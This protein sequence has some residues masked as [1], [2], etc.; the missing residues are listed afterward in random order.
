MATGWIDCINFIADMFTVN[1]DT[2]VG[3]DVFIG[4]IDVKARVDG[5]DTYSFQWDEALTDSDGLTFNDIQTGLR[6]WYQI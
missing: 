4:A 2:T 3:G 6:I 5:N 1:T